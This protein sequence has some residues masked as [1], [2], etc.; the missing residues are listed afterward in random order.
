MISKK[1]RGLNLTSGCTGNVE[2]AFK[3][4]SPLFEKST[5][6]VTTTMMMMMI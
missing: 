4:S 3:L 6:P 5:A 2:A 1:G